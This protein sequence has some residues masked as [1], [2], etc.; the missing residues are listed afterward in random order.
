MKKMIKWLDIINKTGIEIELSGTTAEEDTA[1][2]HS[3]KKAGSAA[4][5][6]AQAVKSGPAKKV[7]APRKMA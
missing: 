5:G 6:K 7:N 1:A 2:D 4:A 3:S